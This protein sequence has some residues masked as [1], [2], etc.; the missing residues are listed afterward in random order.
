MLAYAKGSCQNFIVE[1]GG[2]GSKV[3]TTKLHRGGGGKTKTTKLNE[4]FSHLSGNSPAGG[5]FGDFE[6]TQSKNRAKFVV[7]LCTSL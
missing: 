7:K 3:K 6:L 4:A 5:K 1:K 2:R